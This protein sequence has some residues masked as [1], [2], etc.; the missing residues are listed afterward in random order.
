MLSSSLSLVKTRALARQGRLRL[1]GCHNPREQVPGKNYKPVCLSRAVLNWLIGGG[2]LS[3]VWRTAFCLWSRMYL[4]HFTK[5]L[6]SLLGWMS[7]PMPKLRARFS[8]RGLTTLL[9]SSF[10]TDKGGA[11][12]FLPFLFFPCEVKV[13]VRKPCKYNAS[14]PKL[15]SQKNVVNKYSHGKDGEGNTENLLSSE[16]WWRWSKINEG[17]KFERS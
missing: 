8:N 11:A 13:P 2:I 5:R 6:R 15:T 17:I 3:L 4:G 9:D 10:L 16:P 7:W 1:V 12:T 14:K